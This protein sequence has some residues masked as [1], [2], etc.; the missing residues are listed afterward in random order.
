MSGTYKRN[1][2]VLAASHFVFALS[3]SVSHFSFFF[4]SLASAKLTCEEN[5]DSGGM[6]EINMPQ[7]VNDKLRPSLSPLCGKVKY[8]QVLLLTLPVNKYYLSDTKKW[9]SIIQQMFSAALG[10]SCRCLDK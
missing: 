7:Y 6:K 10:P 8:V 9:H 5:G 2:F 4:L 1:S 3:L